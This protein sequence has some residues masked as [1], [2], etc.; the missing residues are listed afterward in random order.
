[1]KNVMKEF[2]PCSTRGSLSDI[3]N[4]SNGSNEKFLECIH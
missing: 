2:V 3:R 1:M 4:T